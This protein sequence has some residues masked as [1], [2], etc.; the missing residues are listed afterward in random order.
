[1]AGLQGDWLITSSVVL[2][3]MLGVGGVILWLV[4]RKKVVTGDLGIVGEI[5]VAKTE[6]N[7]RGRVFIHGEWWTAVSESRIPPGARVRVTGLDGFTLR[8][9]AVDPTIPRPTSA[10][11]IEVEGKDHGHSL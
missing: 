5:G 2:I 10:I 8:V 7:P 6:L 11:G 3:L 4:N 1:M 9:E